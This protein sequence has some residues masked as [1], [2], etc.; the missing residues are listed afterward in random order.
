MIVKK[1]LMAA[2]VTPIALCPVAHASP[3]A[4]PDGYLQAVYSQGMSGSRDD[5]LNVGVWACQQMK[6]GNNPDTVAQTLLTNKTNTITLA[7]ARELVAD[8]SS[9]ICPGQ[10]APNA[11]PTTPSPD[12]EN[13]DEEV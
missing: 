3:K 9:Y 6:F 11:P 5:L 4:D 2:L 13:H 12:G 10:A 8:A 1:L 7:Q